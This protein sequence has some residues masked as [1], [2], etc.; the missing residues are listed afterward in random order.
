MNADYNRTDWCYIGCAVVVVVVVVVVFCRKEGV[1][2]TCISRVTKV[3][4]VG[5]CFDSAQVLLVMGLR[6]IMK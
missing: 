5:F 6:D 2:C 3:A 4:R 1:E